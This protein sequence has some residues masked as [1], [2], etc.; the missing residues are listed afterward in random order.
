MQQHAEYAIGLRELVK[1]V[2]DLRQGEIAKGHGRT[3]GVCTGHG[4]SYR[5]RTGRR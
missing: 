1:V 5:T 3:R 2:L 4:E